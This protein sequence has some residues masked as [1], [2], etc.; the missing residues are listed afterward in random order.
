MLCEALAVAS[1]PK[2]PLPGPAYCTPLYLSFRRC[3]N[4]AAVDMATI[5]NQPLD[6]RLRCRIVRFNIS[7]GTRGGC[8]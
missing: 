2:V 3:G 5:G 4:R 1:T 8:A 6:E 7:R